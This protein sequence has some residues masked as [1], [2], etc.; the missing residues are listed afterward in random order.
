MQIDVFGLTVTVALGFTVTFVEADEE[1][2][3]AS[4]TTTVYVVVVTGVARGLEIEALLNP[5]EGLHE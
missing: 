3:L 5:V 4:L 1:Q 2:L